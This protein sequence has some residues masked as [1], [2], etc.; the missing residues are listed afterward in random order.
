MA[1]KSYQGEISRIVSIKTHRSQDQ[2]TIAIMGDG[3]VSDY[4]IKTLKK[5]PRILVDFNC[6]AR[7]L[8]ARS[9]NVDNPDIRSIRIGYHFDK[10]RVVIDIKGDVVPAYKDRFKHNTLIVTLK[11]KNSQNE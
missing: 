3:N 4:A 6:A 11:L 7:L 9:I 2:T 8:E 1:K 10:I 5:P